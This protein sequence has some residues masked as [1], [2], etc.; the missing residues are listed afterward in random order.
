MIFSAF[1]RSENENSKTLHHINLYYWSEWKNLL[2]ILRGSKNNFVGQILLN[3]NLKN[4]DIWMFIIRNE[5]KSDDSRLSYS[6]WIIWMLCKSF[7]ENCQLL[8]LFKNFNKTR[9][10]G[11][12]CC[13]N[14]WGI[15]LFPVKITCRQLWQAWKYLDNSVIRS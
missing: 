4:V 6:S 12:C 15:I 3:S 2:W 1:F 7:K 10:K 14:S 11:L 5:K 9:M 8:K 13:I